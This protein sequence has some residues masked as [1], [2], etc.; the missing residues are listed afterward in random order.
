MVTVR[1][2]AGHHGVE[3]RVPAV[4]DPRLRPGEAVAR[5]GGFS[6][7]AQRGGVRPGVR[8]GETV[9]AEQPAAD[10]RREPSVALFVGAEAGKRVAGE[11][12][13]AHAE[14]D[15]EPRPA[16]FFENLQVCDG[17]LLSAAVAGGVR[18]SEQP[19]P[20]EQ[21]ENVAGKTAVSFILGCPWP[22]FAGG[23]VG[24]NV[25]EFFALGGR[26]V[27]HHTHDLN[28]SRRADPEAAHL[29]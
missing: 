15:R 14:A 12:V 28:A 13:D 9:R 1:R 8:L 6:L 19:N 2:G 24:D 3:I 11:E 25:Q 21:P 18:Q 27:A 26:H 23:D 4:R 22:Q 7:G 20:A 16:E 17:G 29:R 5:R 10:H